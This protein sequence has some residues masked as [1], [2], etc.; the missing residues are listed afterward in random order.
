MFDLDFDINE[1]GEMSTTEGVTVEQKATTSIPFQTIDDKQAQSLP[2]TRDASNNDV[3]VNNDVE[4]SPSPEG[5]IAKLQSWNQPRGNIGRFTAAFY[6]MFVFGLSDASY[7]ALLPYV[8][9][10]C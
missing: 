5:S 2:P 9:T 4:L 8:S 3:L 10:T 7:G 1:L 6:S